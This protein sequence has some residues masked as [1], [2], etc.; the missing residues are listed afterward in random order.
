MPRRGEPLLSL[1]T[2][3]I[4][5]Y[6]RQLPPVGPSAQFPLWPHNDR[7]RLPPGELQVSQSGRLR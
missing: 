4:Q 2:R 1:D 7:V 5:G 3:Y 6:D